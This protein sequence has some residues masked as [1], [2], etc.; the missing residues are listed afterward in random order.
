MRPLRLHRWKVITTTTRFI[1]ATKALGG[2]YVV[3]YVLYPGHAASDDSKK[4]DGGLLTTGYRTLVVLPNATTHADKGYV[5][6]KPEPSEPSSTNISE[7]RV[8][9]DL[10]TT[11]RMP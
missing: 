8:Y 1:M 3:M 10:F 4:I 11:F 5:A 6:L 9:T 2:K 7:V